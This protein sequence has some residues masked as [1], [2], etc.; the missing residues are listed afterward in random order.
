[1]IVRD[2]VAATSRPLV[3]S[4][5]T[6][7]IAASESPYLV[8]LRVFANFDSVRC[9][10]GAVLVKGTLRDRKLKGGEEEKNATGTTIG[11]P[12]GPGVKCA[13]KIVI[14]DSVINRDRAFNYSERFREAGGERSG[15]VA[16]KRRSRR[17]SSFFSSSFSP[18]VSAALFAGPGRSFDVFARIRRGSFAE[19]VN[20]QLVII[21]CCEIFVPEDI[22]AEV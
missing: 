13:L 11:R 19:T 16:P 14:Y 2:S 18:L 4:A 7:A 6:C 9:A 22:S 3:L 1:M 21:G 17:A 10:V 15:A 8:R 12:P 20:F 5:G